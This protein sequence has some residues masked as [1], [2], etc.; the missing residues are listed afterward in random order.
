MT[1]EIAG[2]FLKNLITC[3]IAAEKSGLSGEE[4]KAAVMKAYALMLD[5][6][7]LSAPDDFEK[8][9]PLLKDLDLIGG[10]VGLAVFIVNFFSGTGKADFLKMIFKMV[11]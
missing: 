6:L 5:E 7:K 3:V 2:N 9:P 4:K 1:F 10:M 11:K 8:V